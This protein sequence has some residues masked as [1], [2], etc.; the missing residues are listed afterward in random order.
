VPAHALSIA[1]VGRRSYELQDLPDGVEPGLASIGGFAQDERTY[2]AGCHAATV[3][4]DLD[5]G[6]VVLTRLVGATDCGT[7]VHADAAAGQAQGAMVQGAAQV[8][9]EE[10][11]YDDVGNLLT[12]N[13]ISYGIPG[14][15]EVPGLDV[16]FCPTPTD[17]NPLGAKGVGESG[18]VG[19]PAAVQN[20]VVDALADLGVRHIDAPCT[21][22]RVWRA[23]NDG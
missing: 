21:P 8:L 4:V 9:F 16:I 10:V 12:G 5:T 1:E 23:V 18:T 14:P 15:P 17:R 11:A 2:P 20:A 19:A 7:V 22:E 6:L 3:E 13:F